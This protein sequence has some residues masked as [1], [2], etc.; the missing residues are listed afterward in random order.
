MAVDFAA[1]NAACAGCTHSR[2][3]QK[4]DCEIKT[5]LLRPNVA[6]KEFV[7]WARGMYRDGWNCGYRERAI[8]R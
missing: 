7:E 8:T 1:I 4:R 3:G 5:A 6:R 2:P